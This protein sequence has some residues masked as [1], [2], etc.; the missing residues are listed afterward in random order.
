[1]S[2]GTLQSDNNGVMDRDI[3]R[4]VT[5][6]ALAPN[7]TM[8]YLYTAGNVYASPSGQASCHSIGSS[9]SEIGVTNSGRS[10]R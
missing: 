8:Y 6:F 9:V 3:A 1:V 4:A 5:A 2:Y 10:W 7:G